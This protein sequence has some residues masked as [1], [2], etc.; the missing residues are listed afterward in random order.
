MSAPAIRAAFFD[1][2]GTLLSHRTGTVP[3]SAKEALRRL[4]GAGVRLFLS[5]GRHLLEMQELDYVSEFPWD[6]YITMNGQ[7]CY[8]A[9]GVYFRQPIDRE[10]VEGLIRLSAEMDIPCMFVEEDDIYIGHY[11]DTVRSVLREIHTPLPRLEDL[12]RGLEK[13]V[14]L[15]VIY[16]TE[17]KRRQL[18]HRLKSVRAMSWHPLA[19]DVIHREGSKARGIRLTCERYGIPLEETMAFGDGENDLEMLREVGVG[20]A[21][22]NASP[23]VKAACRYVTADID[24]DGILKALERF[25]VI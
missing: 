6:G 13:D 18:V 10:D 12:R 1:V 7:F 19:F 16:C 25:G 21:M 4:R 2:D 8:D 9:D 14:Y 23:E 17:E 3:S 24:E 11:N 20:V 5:T 22:G 15:A